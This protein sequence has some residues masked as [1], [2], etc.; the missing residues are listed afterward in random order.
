[1]RPKLGSGLLLCL[2]AAV[3]GS[4]STAQAWTRTVVKG[5]KVTTTIVPTEVRYGLV[6]G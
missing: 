1:M 4:S 2:F 3:L 6:F 5:A